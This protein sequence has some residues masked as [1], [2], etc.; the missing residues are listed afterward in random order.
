MTRRA[1][2]SV[3]RKAKLLVVKKGRSSRPQENPSLESVGG[4]ASVGKS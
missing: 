4:T 3:G 1:Q 2:K